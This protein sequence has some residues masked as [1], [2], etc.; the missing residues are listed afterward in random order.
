MAEYEALNRALDAQLVERGLRRHPDDGRRPRQ[1]DQRAWFAYIA[2]NM[3]DLF[4]AYSVHVYWDYWN[5]PFF[6][7]SR[8]KDIRKILTEELSA[9]AASPPT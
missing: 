9:A 6:K 1:H 8:L 2:A 5:T 3:N 4:D 7:E